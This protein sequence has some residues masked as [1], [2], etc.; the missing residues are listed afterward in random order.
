MTEIFIF[1]LSTIL[2]LVFDFLPKM[3]IYVGFRR[4]LAENYWC[5][6]LQRERAP[7]IESWN[8]RGINQHRWKRDNEH[9]ELKIP[10]ENRSFHKKQ[11][12]FSNQP[13]LTLRDSSNT[14]PSTLDYLEANY[15]LKM[16]N[17]F[18]HD[19]D[20]EMTNVQI[21][22][23]MLQAEE[24]NNKKQQIMKCHE[25]QYKRINVEQLI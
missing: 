2:A 6:Y 8:T 15:T 23:F 19:I 20:K 22:L 16:P 1:L 5:A 7:K 13:F 17:M 24:S 10:D 18:L 14:I 21:I 9:R 4:Y 12:F 25:S 3:W 11:G